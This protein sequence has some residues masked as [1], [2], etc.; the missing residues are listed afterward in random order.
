[1]HAVSPSTWRCRPRTWPSILRSLVSMSSTWS[2]RPCSTSCSAGDPPRSHGASSSALP[3]LGRP[4]DGGSAMWASS[5]PDRDKRRTG[6]NRHSTP[7][8]AIRASATTSDPPS[9]FLPFAVHRAI[10]H[11]GPGR[12]PAGES[13]LDGL[14]ARPPDHGRKGGSAVVG[15]NEVSVQP[16]QQHGE[17]RPL[18][19]RAGRGDSA[20]VRVGQLGDDGEADAAA[21]AGLR[22]ASTPEA[23]EHLRELVGGKCLVLYRSP[24]SWRARRSAQHEG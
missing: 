16:R 22:A 14:V 12:A 24:P 2:V 8:E 23:L 15:G 4:G 1:M 7:A 20:P 19:G 13:D 11:T 21:R 5:A 17:R 3:A 10:G 9:G 6:R 18:A